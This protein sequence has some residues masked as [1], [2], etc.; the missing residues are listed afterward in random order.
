MEVLALQGSPRLSGNTQTL[1]NA[2]LGGLPSEAQIHRYNVSKLNVHPCTSCYACKNLG[3]C[4]IS[5]DMK[6]LYPALAK[7]PLVIIATPIYFY[8]FSAQLKAV[9]DRCQ[10]FWNN[11]QT[12]ID[13]RTSVLLL[14]GGAA[15][16]SRAGRDAVESCARIFCECIGAPLKHTLAALGTDANPAVEQQELLTQAAILAKEL[17]AN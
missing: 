14:T 13:S 8:G 12:R 9:V 11:P 3:R 7:H 2:F 6:L 1:L 10:T 4:V 5:D 16:K 15:D 17:S